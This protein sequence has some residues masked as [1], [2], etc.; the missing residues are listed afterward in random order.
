MSDD[1]EPN[2]RFR[3][4]ETGNPDYNP[5]CDVD[6][7]VS[8]DQDYAFVTINIGVN[9]LQAEWVKQQLLSDHSVQ[10][11]SDSSRKVLDAVGF[12]LP[13]STQS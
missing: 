12:D 11:T 4:D 13:G 5:Y 9:G 7:I 3:L 8:T 6:V 1:T 2:I 10:P